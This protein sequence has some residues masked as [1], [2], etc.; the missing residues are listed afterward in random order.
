MENFIGFFQA[1]AAFISVVSIVVFLHEFG[2]YIVAKWCGVR[3]ETFSIGFGKEIYGWTDKSGTRWKI[4]MLPLG[5]YVAMFGDSDPA[6][7]PDEAKLNA[8][9]E[10]DKKWAFHY[11]PLHK[12]AAVVVA[13]PM[14]NFITAIAIM[15]AMIYSFGYIYSSGA[16]SSVI[17]G[18]AAEAVGIREGDVILELDGN[19]ITEFSD[20]KA[21]VA[22]NPEKEMLALIKRGE[23][24]IELKVTPKVTEITDVLGKS[25]K[26]GLLGIS[27]TKPEIREMGLYDSFTQAFK[28]AKT[29]CV[30]NLTALKQMIMGERSV[31]DLTGPIGIARV[32]KKYLSAGWEDGWKGILHAFTERVVQ[33][34]LALG[35]MNLLPIPALDGGHLLY[36]S[37]EGL[38]GKPMAVKIQ[39]F[40]M[41]LGIACLI[42]LMVI[43]VFND[44]SNLGFLG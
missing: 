24:V 41:R 29:F 22:I 34:S 43:A 18:S 19:K 20:L 14:A 21:V 15:T 2:H 37:I 39:D 1:V 17:P 3:V 12:K 23:E 4:S 10:E 28:N 13:G 11:K 44:L 25:H 32:S 36:Y 8:M 7:N 42:C 38:R 6:S 26:I 35:L 30:T 16:V 33:I 5:G 27:S 9:T 40:T 31:K